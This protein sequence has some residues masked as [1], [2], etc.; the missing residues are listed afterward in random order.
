MAIDQGAAQ[1]MREDL[2]ALDGIS[3]KK[4][5]GGL[6]YMRGGH[7]LTGVVS[8]GALLYR[9]GK[10]RQDVALDLPGVSMMQGNGRTMGGFVILQGDAQADDDLR[11]R[12]LSMALEN[13]AELPPKE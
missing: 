9:V 8:H 1:M 12:L 4:M 2:A 6:G 5:F 13:A 11:A 10:T 3:E 7:M